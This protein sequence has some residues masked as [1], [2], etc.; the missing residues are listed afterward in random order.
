MVLGCGFLITLASF[1]VACIMIAPLKKYWEFE[2]NLLIAETQLGLYE[3]MNSCVDQFT[4]LDLSMIRD[5]IKTNREM[6]ETITGLLVFCQ[7]VTA[8]SILLLIAVFSLGCGNPARSIKEN[9]SC[10]QFKRQFEG[11]Y[12]LTKRGIIF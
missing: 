5:V 8:F 12:K 7:C 4:R 2:S 3:R 6:T 1:I 9:M 10:E 11:M